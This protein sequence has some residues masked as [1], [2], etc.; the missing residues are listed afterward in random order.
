MF[1]SLISSSQLPAPPHSRGKA[2]HHQWE[3]PDISPISDYGRARLCGPR[4]IPIF[5][6][7]L[8]AP[9]ILSQSMSAKE[10]NDCCPA[11]PQEEGIGPPTCLYDNHC[12]GLKV[13]DGEK[14]NKSALQ[15]MC[16]KVRDGKWS[17]VGDNKTSLG[18]RNSERHPGQE[19]DTAQ[20]NR[21]QNNRQ[22]SRSPRSFCGIS[23]LLGAWDIYYLALDVHVIIGQ[24]PHLPQASVLAPNVYGHPIAQ[25]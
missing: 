11:I 4:E 24:R 16:M 2:L 19:A 10:P 23:E 18:N 5:N 22:H 8:S 6:S 9:S 13:L 17:R 12:L 20:R 25:H 14:R 7:F 1:R 21:S 15:P 3:T